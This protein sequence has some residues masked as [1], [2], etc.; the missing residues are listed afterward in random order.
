[1]SLRRSEPIGL[2]GVS[3][4]I[5][6]KKEESLELRRK[7]KGSQCEKRKRVKCAGMLKREERI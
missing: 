6:E 1:M 3:K 4:Q 5:T 7:S 2:Q